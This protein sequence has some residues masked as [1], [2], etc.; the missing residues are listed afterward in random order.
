[1]ALLCKNVGPPYSVLEGFYLHPIEEQSW[2]VFRLD[3][4]YK[5]IENLIHSQDHLA[6]N[7]GV[8]LLPFYPF[9]IQH[10]VER[11]LSNVLACH[12]DQESTAWARFI[13]FVRFPEGP[14]HLTAWRTFLG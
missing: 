14:E 6:K 9:P 3:V 10:E 11:L 7:L 5:I 13:R 12:D 4:D 1:M 8:S 2:E